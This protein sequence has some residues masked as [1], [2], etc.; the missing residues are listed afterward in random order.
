MEKCN[1]SSSPL[2]FG[3]T[4][5]CSITSM[6]P[7]NVFANWGGGTGKKETC[8]PE[9]AVLVPSQWGAASGVVNPLNELF[10]HISFSR[11]FRVRNSLSQL[12]GNIWKDSTQLEPQVL[13]VVS[14]GNGLLHPDWLKV[15]REYPFPHGTQGDFW[16]L[17]GLACWVSLCHAGCLVP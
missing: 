14:L 7:Y 15:C 12:D 1:F 6:A 11:L 13:H 2:P 16:H 8:F 3:C 9:K 4:V 5:S 17:Q 10:L